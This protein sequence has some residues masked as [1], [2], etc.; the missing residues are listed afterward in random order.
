[1]TTKEQER[2]ALAQIRKIVE[3]LGEMSY[4]GTALDGCLQDA[5]DNIDMDAAFSM[6]SRWEIAEENVKKLQGEQNTANTLNAKLTQRAERAEASMMNAELASQIS[7]DYEISIRTANDELREASAVLIGMIGNISE[8]DEE[9][10]Q[11]VMRQIAALKR[12]IASQEETK[13]KINKYIK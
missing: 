4:I 12:K 5:D 8:T 1:M 3:G 7:A 13:S 2:K 6:K 9:T 10:F 11:K